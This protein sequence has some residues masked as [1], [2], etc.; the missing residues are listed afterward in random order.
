MKEL[1]ATLLLRPLNF[2]TLATHL[3]G[4]AS[5]GTYEDGAIAALLIV[6]VGPPA[7][8]P[9]GARQPA[10]GSADSGMTELRRIKTTLAGAD[11]AFV[12]PGGAEW[13]MAGP[14]GRAA[15]RSAPS[16]MDQ[17]YRPEPNEAAL[18]RVAAPPAASLAVERRDAALWRHRRGRRRHRSTWRRA[19]SWRWSAT[20]DRESRRCSG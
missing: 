2:E 4:E 3:Y 16:G 14:A 12:A 15:L 11:Y 18:A 1:P 9:A 8:D 10:G 7:G 20:R 6:L 5:R 19:R 13:Q 17:V